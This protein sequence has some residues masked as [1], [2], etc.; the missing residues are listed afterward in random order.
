MEEEAQE[1]N[2]KSI[3]VDSSIV[4]SSS[5]HQNP[6]ELLYSINT[7][8]TILSPKLSRIKNPRKVS[9]SERKRGST[10]P[11]VKQTKSHVKPKGR[12]FNTR[13]GRR[14]EDSG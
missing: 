10:Q 12:L 3:M 8:S 14:Y 11:V 1:T 6:G 9:M 4:D 2:L 5:G 7:M 13:D